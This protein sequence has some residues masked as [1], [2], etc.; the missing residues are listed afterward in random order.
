MDMQMPEM[1]GYTATRMLRA[2]G[3]SGAIIAVTAHAMAADRQKCLDAGCDGYA[4]K[5]I[6][7]DALL[8]TIR[9]VLD[10]QRLGDD[11]GC[12][13]PSALPAALSPVAHPDT[14][15]TG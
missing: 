14:S 12:P 15:R 3:Y 9:H 5:P 4:S 13:A 1:D 11:A 7:R 2:R 6:K 8:A 10:R